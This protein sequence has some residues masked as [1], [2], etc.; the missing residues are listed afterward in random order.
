M[1]ALVSLVVAL[2]VAGSLAGYAAAQ[3]GEDIVVAG[4]VVFKV[5]TSGQAKSA[6]ERAVLITRRITDALSIGRVLQSDIVLRTDRGTPA[7][8]ARNVLIVTVSAEDAK[9]NATTVE[10][11]AQ[12]WLRNLRSAL[13]E[14]VPLPAMSP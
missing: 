6:H 3:A 9:L 4:Q 8:Y 12:V 14:A 10:A 7:I 13:P 11:L 1:R 5:R 2:C